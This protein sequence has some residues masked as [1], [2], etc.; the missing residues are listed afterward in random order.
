[1]L[2]LKSVNALSWVAVIVACLVG[3]VSYA[4]SSSD[5][6]AIKEVRKE[7]REA[8][9]KIKLY[10]SDQRDEAIDKVKDVLDKMDERIERME[11]RLDEKS[12][13]MDITARKKTK[14]T[15]KTLRKQ[16]NQLSEWYGS[17]K[18]SSNEAWQDIKSGFMDSY[19]SMMNAL[20]EAE[21]AY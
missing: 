7:M 3:A 14:S 1:M 13:K 15:L 12:G 11:D 4:K 5:K 19:E 8:A 17:M 10:S 9:E 2:M 6:T 16:R 18:N 21:D 20:D